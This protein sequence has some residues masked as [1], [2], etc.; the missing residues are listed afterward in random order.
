[1]ICLPKDSASLRRAIGLFANYS[2]WIPNFSRKLQPL[3]SVEQF[4][5]S[6]LQNNTF[7]E[8]ELIIYKSFL[9]AIDP[10]DPFT[11]ET[12]AL[13]Y[14]LQRLLLKMGGLL[15]FSLEHT[16]T[17]KKYPIIENEACAIAESLKK[18]RHYLLGRRLYLLT[19]QKSVAF[20]LQNHAGKIK[21]YTTQRWRQEQSDYNY[22]RTTS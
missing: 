19:D 6:N 14:L 8:F 12:D 7:E 18:W 16:V 10:K 20:M 1:M 9:S 11:V 15:R 13:T 21:N 17:E 22:K 2:T 4:S 3:T 5:L